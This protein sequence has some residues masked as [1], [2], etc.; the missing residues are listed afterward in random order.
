MNFK[1]CPLYGIKSKKMLKNL[2]H[3]N[4]NK[5]FKQ[6]YVSTLISPYIDFN[7]KPRLIEPPKEELKNIQR[8]IK[9]MLNKIEVPNN[10][11]SGI[12]NRSYINNA[13]YHTEYSYIDSTY[14]TKNKPKTIFKIDFHSF[15]PTIRREY[16]YKFFLNDLNCAPDI[17]DILTN[18]TTID[19]KKSNTN[20][21]DAIYTFLKNKDINCTNHLISGAP[22][23]QIMS[24]LVN[25]KMF[26]E[27]Q[28]VSDKNNIK[29]SVYV[30]DITFSSE[31]NISNKF[32][33]K[34]FSI[35]KKYNYSISKSKVKKYTKSYPKLITGV[36]IDSNGKPKIKNSLRL[37]IINE[38]KHLQSNPHDDN[39]RN[40]LNGL[41]VAARQITPNAF[42][43][44]YKFVSNYK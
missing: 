34:I 42:P 30:D 31:N 2:L 9:G 29:M 8:L 25:Y 6:N 32:I 43:N 26:N 38:Y 22:T 4:N 14:H 23:S 19:I 15:F 20:N 27:M 40:R 13:F 41:L 21:I 33:K 35:V 24:Y 44:I 11:F 1:E 17:A 36:I 7:K 16:V 39:S 3:I 18:F 12:K 28:K 5:L 37:K 10:I